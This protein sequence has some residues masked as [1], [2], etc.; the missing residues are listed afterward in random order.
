MSSDF[1]LARDRDAWATIRGFVYQVELTIDR[2]LRLDAEHDL[3]LEAGEDIDIVAQAWNAGDDGPERILEQVKHREVSITLRSPEA[4]A[5]IASFAEHRAEN[6]GRK[7]QFRFVTNTDPALERPSPMHPYTGIVA[8]EAV[9][10]GATLNGATKASLVAGIREILRSA[11]RP[12]DFNAMTW[13]RLEEVVAGGVSELESLIGDFQW[14]MRQTESSELARR[15]QS[16]LRSLGKGTEEKVAEYQFYRLFVYVI[17]L[18][19]NR[20]IKRLTAAERDRVLQLPVPDALENVRLSK[21]G[22]TLDSLRNV[23][24]QQGRQIETLACQLNSMLGPTPGVLLFEPP[25]DLSVPTGVQRGA[26]RAS[27][28]HTILAGAMSHVWTAIHGGAGSGKTELV[29]LAANSLGSPPPWIRLRDLSP[30]AAVVRLRAV[31]RE[32]GADLSSRDRDAWYKAV[33]ERLGAGAVV[34][35]DDVPRLYAGDELSEELIH[36]VAAF[37]RA[38]I[39]LVTTSAY[40]PSPSICER[41]GSMQPEPIPAPLLLDDEVREL[42]VAHDAPSA[43]LEDNVCRAVNR[44]THG[45]P[46]LAARGIR[47]LQEAGWPPV[48]RLVEIVGALEIDPDTLRRLLSTVSQPERLELLRR[49]TLILGVFGMDDASAVAAVAPEIG[50]LREHIDALSGPWLQLESKSRYLVSPLIRDLGETELLP[51]VRRAVH[52]SLASHIVSRS[53]LN[54]YDVLSAVHHF[55]H[56]ESVDRAAILLC[57]ALHEV[58]ATED[59]SSA[60][61]LLSTWYREPLA[62]DVNRGLRLYLRSLQV[63]TA[64]MVGLQD[65]AIEAELA[66]AASAGLPSQEAWAIVATLIIATPAI[67]RH[68]L[69]RANGIFLTALRHLAIAQLPL[70]G[71]PMADLLP[72]PLEQWI[73]QFASFAT[74]SDDVES[75]LD[76]LASLTPD[77]LSRAVCSELYPQ[78]CMALSNVLWLHEAEKFKADRRWDHIDAA[79]SKLAERAIEI[80]LEALW[81]WAVRAR[82]IV[83]ADYVN[84]LDDALAIG[85]EALSH[86]SNDAV[87]QFA[88]NEILGVEYRIAGKTADAKKHLLVALGQATDDFAVIKIRTTIFLSAVVGLEDRAGAVVLVEQA[89][90]AARREPGLPEAEIIKILCEL[91]IAKW[92]AH[93]VAAAFPTW[94]DAAGRLLAIKDSTSTWRALCMVFGHTSGYLTSLASDGEPPEEKPQGET[95]AAPQPTMFLGYRAEVSRLYDDSNF[96]TILTQLSLFAE[97]VGD[98]ERATE[99]ALRGMDEARTRGDVVSTSLLAPRLAA[100]LVSTDRFAAAIDI[101]LVEGMA[102]VKGIASRLADSALKV[103]VPDRLDSNQVR[104][105]DAEFFAVKVSLMPVALRLASTWLEHPTELEECADDAIAAYRYIESTAIDPEIWSAAAQLLDRIFRHRTSARA[106]SSQATDLAQRH[107]AVFHA[108]AYLG[109]TLQDDINLESAA[110]IHW[111]ILLVLRNERRTVP[112]ERLMFM[113]VIEAFW[114][115]AITEQRFRFRTPLLAIEPIKRALV[116]PPDSRTEEILRAVA[117]GLGIALRNP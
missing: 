90:A 77:E 86:A 96:A 114:R 80:G 27:T 11:K 50:A 104:T 42:L 45:H 92:L 115:K 102:A 31:A 58:R 26:L 37:G 87:V 81:A 25:P 22:V 74:S 15:L 39:H 64:D 65:D 49:M 62:A 61:L 89:L 73:W 6:T 67:A 40:A 32:Y 20:G 91:A 109:A 4:L 97:A 30:D 34:V 85:E 23:V 5:A 99:W 56:G 95:Y 10:T 41:L 116:A 54:A 43:W 117:A 12:K 3:E 28:V 105:S 47:S 76:T 9:R 60:R 78:A 35:V 21:I 57:W 107:G 111:E 51:S 36:L 98:D 93:G 103:V 8:W 48:S 16:E 79:L 44:C 1:H 59:Q 71:G 100:K 13:M 88:L 7:L 38:G 75:W 18:L 63:A 108:V 19:C 112:L 106:L 46:L 83:A 72:V 82:V 110:R 14:S 33:A 17:E 52:R 24:E 69:P 113:P 101:S 66:E 29:I 84:R 94:D 2:W 55:R 68:N 53:T 70:Q